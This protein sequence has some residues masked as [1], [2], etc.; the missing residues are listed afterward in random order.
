MSLH[1]VSRLV[2]GGSVRP[3]VA[4][5]ILEFHAAR[6]LLLIQHCGTRNQIKGL[7]K[8]AKLDFFVRYPAF[9]NRIAD[10][11]SRKNVVHADSPMVRHHYGPWD[12]RYYQV[13]A[14][15]E[16]AGLIDVSHDE[17]AYSVAL[18]TIGLETARELSEDRPFLDLVTHMRSVKLQLGRKSGTALKKM[19]YRE[20]DTE[21]AERDLGEI[22]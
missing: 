11:T 17:S 20:F 8:L 18:T 9:F 6:I 4:D 16:S 19:I 21:V 14:F 1:R 10:T 15:L 7:T 5:D 22:I 13:L 3:I 2:G 12:H